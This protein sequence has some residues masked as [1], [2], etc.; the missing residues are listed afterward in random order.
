MKSTCKPHALPAGK[1]TT[2]TI[3]LGVIRKLLEFTVR[4]GAYSSKSHASLVPSSHPTLM[5][6]ASRSFWFRNM[7]GV[8]IENPL[9]FPGEDT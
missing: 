7:S 5:K 1:H 8:T 4:W 3:D 6:P 9:L 2:A